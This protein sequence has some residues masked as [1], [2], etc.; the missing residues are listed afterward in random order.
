LQEIT[1]GAAGQSLNGSPDDASKGVDA[2]Q[3]KLRKLES[4]SRIRGCLLNKDCGAHEPVFLEKLCV[5][6]KNVSDSIVVSSVF[7]ALNLML[8]KNALDSM[9][10]VLLA[11]V[12]TNSR[13]FAVT[14]TEIHTPYGFFRRCTEFDPMHTLAECVKTL[15]RRK[16]VKVLSFLPVVECVLQTDD[17]A[18]RPVVASCIRLLADDIGNRDSPRVDLNRLAIDGIDLLSSKLVSYSEFSDTIVELNKIRGLKGTNAYQKQSKTMQSIASK[19]GD[20]SSNASNSQAQSR[21]RKEIEDAKCKPSPDSRGPLRRRF[22]AGELCS[23]GFAPESKFGSKPQVEGES[24]F[25]IG[26]G[27]CKSKKPSLRSGS[28]GIDDVVKEPLQLGS[29]ASQSPAA[30]PKWNPKEPAIDD[31]SG[32][33]VACVVSDI[34]SIAVDSAICGE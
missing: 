5:L 23:S 12:F 30:S 29:I 16:N 2:A 19:L 26:I 14:N 33:A 17:W 34:I 27:E 32:S 24:N 22:K 31:A 11:K 28:G 21:K 8:S 6:L 15:P 13:D 1:R 7:S 3:I 18:N 10:P 4:I 20:M 9:L 25:V